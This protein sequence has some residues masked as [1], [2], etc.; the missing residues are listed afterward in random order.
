MKI[1]KKIIFG[2]ILVISILLSVNIALIYKYFNLI[3]DIE[4]LKLYQIDELNISHDIAFQ[5]QRIKS[6]LRE[7]LLELEEGD[8]RNELEWAD[9][10][11]S[12]HLPKLL[13]SSKSLKNITHDGS[14]HARSEIIRE[15]EIR[16]YR[17]V[18]S[19]YSMVSQFV[20]SILRLQNSYFDKDVKSSILI[21][22]RDI[23]P[24]S[25]EIQNLINDLIFHAEN[26]VNELIESLHIVSHKILKFGIYSSILSIIIALFIAILISR[27]ISKPINKVI[28]STNRL[29][30]GK[31]DTIVDIKTKGEI[32]DL[33]DSFNEMSIELN[34]KVSYINDLNK[35]LYESNITKDTFL[36]IIAHDLKNPFTI[37]MGF[38]D[39]L[40]IQYDKLDDN[41]RKEYINEIY[42][43][44][45][46][47][48]ELLENLL[49][50]SRVQSD[51]IIIKKESLKINQILGQSLQNY[52]ILAEQKGI[53]II[54]EVPDNSIIYA[55]KFTLLVIVNNALSNAIKFTNSE[56]FISVD[57]NTSNNEVRLI[58]KD[59]GIGMDKETL[60][61]LMSSEGYS[62]IGTNNETGTGLGLILIKE[63]IK[64]NDAKLEINSEMGKG[65]ELCFI[66]PNQ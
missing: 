39:L 33:A 1:W 58:V 37:I 23:E 38:S 4:E 18:D 63:F 27:S 61:K 16:E 6:N 13:N 24:I 7:F 3:D 19:L 26:E 43:S 46:L 57:V 53:K 35:E 45:K 60:E 17:K 25:R 32:Q 10:V 36:S 64:K 31:L 54:N 49:S 50:W 40:R 66:F 51:K 62:S 8:E 47:T 59:T 14:Q 12:N 29:K 2:F 55:D 41:K 9:N 30:E 44:S 11:V 28:D 20:P 22:E 56:G 52:S 48:K 21:F 34:S 42:K 65:C 5:V 15:C